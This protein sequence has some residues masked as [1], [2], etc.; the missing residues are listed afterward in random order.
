LEKKIS[1]KSKNR[2]FLA[3]FFYSILILGIVLSPT[4]EGVYLFGWR[5]PELCASKQFFNFDCLGC[6]LTRS[7][8][9]TMQ[10][11]YVQAWEMHALGIPITFTFL[12]VGTINLYRFF[13]PKV[14]KL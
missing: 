10:G 8:C 5:L 13:F 12:S 11:K 4:S 14:E 9:F 7:V 1:A 2:L 3:M 6:G